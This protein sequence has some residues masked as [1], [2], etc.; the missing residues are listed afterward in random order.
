MTTERSN[1]GRA[2]G[3]WRRDA[4]MLGQPHS[5]NPLLLVTPTGVLKVV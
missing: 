4:T 3:V 2:V 1:G 5:K